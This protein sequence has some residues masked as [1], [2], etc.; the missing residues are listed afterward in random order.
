MLSCLCQVTKLKF[1]EDGDDRINCDLKICQFH[2][3][4][5]PLEYCLKVVLRN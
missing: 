4:S 5:I 1:V 2:T 3:L